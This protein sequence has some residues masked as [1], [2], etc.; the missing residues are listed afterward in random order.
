M[1]SARMR[2]DDLPNEVVLFVCQQFFEQAGARRWPAPKVKE[3]AA[4]ANR[5]L[6]E[7]RPDAA[8]EFT[9][10][11]IYPVLREAF[12]RGFLQYSPPIEEEMKRWLAN[13]TGCPNDCFRVVNAIDPATARDQV[14]AA[15]AELLIDLIREAGEQPAIASDGRIHIGIPAGYT[16]MMTCRHLAA[17]LRA[18]S[19]VPDLVFHSLTTGWKIDRPQEDPTALCGLFLDLPVNVNW[20]GLFSEPVVRTGLRS[21]AM[22]Q[23]VLDKPGVSEPRRLR[24]DISIVLTAHGNAEGSYLEELVRELEPKAVDQLRKQGWI[25]DVCFSP[26]NEHGPIESGV[27]V[28]AVTLFNLSELQQ[29]ASQD[30]RSV[31]LVSA[32]TVVPDS[33][34]TSAPRSQSLLPLLQQ[35]ET[36]RCWTHVVTDAS[37][38]REVI[39]PR[40]R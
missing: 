2:V 12:L 35:R 3:I 18:A 25:G 20:V 26:F 6:K 13:W 11:Q 17:R 5:R 39:R 27:S 16:S 36:L 1:P 8:Y 40:Q 29:L 31:V 7:L 24:D 14:C 9:R 37:T 23:K 21:D 19:D 10:E 30:G 33:D 28:R 4:T 15:A 38:V 32:P 22:F 34:Q